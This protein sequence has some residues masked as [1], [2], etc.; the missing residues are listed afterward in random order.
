MS[1]VRVVGSGTF[2]PQECE[3]PE[4]D[5]T[6]M[7]TIAFMRATLDVGLRYLR[8]PD[9]L[10][11]FDFWNGILF[12]ITSP[13]TRS[14]HLQH[15]QLEVV[16]DISVFLFGLHFEN[17][18]LRNVAK[19]NCHVF[20]RYVNCFLGLCARDSRAGLRIVPASRGY[21]HCSR[22]LLETIPGSAIPLDLCFV[23]CVVFRRN[24]VI[25]RLGRAQQPCLCASDLF[26]LSLYAQLEHEE[27]G[28]DGPVRL[29]DPNYVNI[30]NPPSVKHRAAFLRVDGVLEHCSIAST[31]LGGNSPFVAV[32]V[33]KGAYAKERREVI[34]SV[35]AL[36]AAETEGAYRDVPPRAP[37]SMP[38]LVRLIITNR[39]NGEYFEESGVVSDASRRVGDLLVERVVE[40]AADAMADGMTVFMWSDELF[41]FVYQL[42]FVDERGQILAPDEPLPVGVG[43]DKI[44]AEL[45]PRKIVT[46]YQVFTVYVATVEP[47]TI[48]RI[49]AERIAGL[50]KARLKLTMSLP[51]MRAGFADHRN[52]R[53]PI[54]FASPRHG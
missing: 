22:C 45:Y 50:S 21:G 15:A 19:S 3:H 5:Q 52:R 44:T 32:F 42:A 41:R 38:G 36:I 37:S 28:S 35:L 6:I 53:S 1:V 40:K 26:L 13:R 39:I 17:V 7:S 11:V 2:Y 46:V 27:S 9:H 54:R 25:V 23:E 43:F 29:F 4:G 49:N 8:T 12:A 47:A 20:E 51:N 10:T 48:I 33:T 31:R 16:R 34:M 24:S 18:M 30:R 14:P